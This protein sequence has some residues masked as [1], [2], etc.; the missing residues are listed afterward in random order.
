MGRGVFVLLFVLVRGKE[1]EQIFPP[2]KQ[3]KLGPEWGHKLWQEEEKRGDEKG[4]GK[5]GKKGVRT[6]FRSSPPLLL[7]RATKKK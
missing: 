1:E 7:I 5:E 4:R 2:Q 3:V 6:V